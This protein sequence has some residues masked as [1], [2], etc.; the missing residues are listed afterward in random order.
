MS[1]F[2]VKAG[3][4]HLS[5]VSVGGLYTS[6]YISELGV[7]FDLGMA[8]RSHVGARAVFISHGHADHIGA[9]QTFL[10]LRGL[11]RL[12]PP[13]TYLPEEFLDDFRDGVLAFN[14]RKTGKNKFEFRGLKPQDTGLLSGGIEYESFRTEHSIPSLGY[15]LFRR[16]NKLKKEYIGRPGE[17]IRCLKLQGA[18]LFEQHQRTEVVYATDTR[19]DVFDRQPELARTKLLILEATFLEKELNAKEARGRFHVHLD[20]I[21]ERE[22]LF[23]PTEA[24]VLMHF[25]Q[26]YSPARVR[27][28]LKRRLPPRLLAKVI[29]FCPL[30]GPWPG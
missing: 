2:K 8:L 16:V 3:P 17:E 29:P 5:G 4:Y 12:A 28:I 30:N 14:R 1:I 24:L 15:R 20:E 13:P 7:L 18:D 25:S 22:D 21:I 11:S 9:Y 27:E 6:I 26:F 23:E 19:I 10:G